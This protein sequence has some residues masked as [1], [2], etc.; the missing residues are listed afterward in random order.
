[1]DKFDKMYATYYGIIM[2]VIITGLFL[3]FWSLT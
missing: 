1:M 2:G 3:F